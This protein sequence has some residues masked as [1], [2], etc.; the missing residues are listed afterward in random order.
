MAVNYA[1]QAEF[2]GRI[3]SPI[4]APSVE[5]TAHAKSSSFVEK[6]NFIGSIQN[7]LSFSRVVVCRQAPPGP[8]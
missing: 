6:A 3:R 5:V 2:L 8:R 1:A 7:F 4:A